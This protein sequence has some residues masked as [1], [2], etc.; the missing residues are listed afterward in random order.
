M[1]VLI[2]GQICLFNFKGTFFAGSGS[3][4]TSLI[5]TTTDYCMLGDGR[6]HANTSACT[7]VLLCD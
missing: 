7:T 2:A 5:F 3:R 1:I 4:P 6:V